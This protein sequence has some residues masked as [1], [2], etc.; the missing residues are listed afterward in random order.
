MEE[1]R[2]DGSAVVGVR[3][4]IRVGD[5]L[6]FIG[7]GMRSHRLRLDGLLLFD[8]EGGTLG[9]D[10][11]NPNQRIIM[12]PPFSVEPFDLIRR[13]KNLHAM[14]DYKVYARSGSE[15]WLRDLLFLLLLFS[16]PFLASLGRLPL[17]L[18]TKGRMPRSPRH[19]GAGDLI[20]T[21]PDHLNRFGNPAAALLAQR[22]LARAS[23]DRTSSPSV[24]HG[25]VRPAD[26]ARGLCHC[27][28]LYDRRTALLSAILLGSCT[29][30]ALLSRGI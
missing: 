2:G 21:S 16:V 5:E 20:T 30:F 8:P 23:S 7:P 26:S 28:R 24:F 10:A 13:G 27:R 22:G 17:F 3:N 15:G 1:L 4:R 19:A 11:A 14:R 6:E 29:G 9:G 12:R 25:P 18:P